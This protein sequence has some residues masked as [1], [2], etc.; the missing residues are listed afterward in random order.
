MA[1]YN[2]AGQITTIWIGTVPLLVLRVL[3]PGRQPTTRPHSHETMFAAG[4][5]V[6]TDVR[7]ADECVGQSMGLEL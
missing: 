3:D 1:P 4:L 5:G 2:T 7:E 6:N